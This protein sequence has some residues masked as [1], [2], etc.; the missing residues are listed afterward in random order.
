MLKTGYRNIDRIG[1]LRDRFSP[2]FLQFRQGHCLILTFG[3]LWSD[4]VG[5]SRFS[6]TFKA[7]FYEAGES[8][9]QI[10]KKDDGLFGNQ[11]E[12]ASFTGWWTLREEGGKCKWKGVAMRRN[13]QKRELDGNRPPGVSFNR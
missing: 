3:R 4:I 8:L 11:L 5:W 1:S 2:S 10:G 9:D 7:S 13:E 12:H 6:R